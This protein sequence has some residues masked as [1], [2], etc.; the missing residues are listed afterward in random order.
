M[1]NELYVHSLIPA[2]FL[3]VENTSISGEMLYF[4][5]AE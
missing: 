3:K 2:P 5:I 4:N 1:L